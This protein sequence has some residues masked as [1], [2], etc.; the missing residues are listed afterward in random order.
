MIR[1]EISNNQ[2][3]Q[4]A[5]WIKIL[6]YYFSSQTFLS[7]VSH[8]DFLRILVC[9]QMKTVHKKPASIGREKQTQ[10]ALACTSKAIK[11]CDHNHIL[12]NWI[13]HANR[14]THSLPLRL[15]TWISA[16]SYLAYY[17]ILLCGQNQTYMRC[18]NYT[19]ALRNTI[20][21]N[22]NH[23]VRL[24]FMWTDHF[25]SAFKPTSF[26]FCFLNRHHNPAR[27]WKTFWNKKRAKQLWMQFHE[28][29]F[30]M[31]EHSRH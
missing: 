9:W 12:P 25:R 29:L 18:I 10:G 30:S 24:P 31:L 8:Y 7:W 20:V 21:R 27:C 22:W 3:S 1:A 15:K 19:L 11:N 5:S 13:K 26:M 14:C 17:K 23:T 16:V 4:T 6:N 2:R 28:E